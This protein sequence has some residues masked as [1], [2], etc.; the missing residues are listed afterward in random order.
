MTLR[1]GADAQLLV[2]GVAWVEQRDT[3]G[4]LPGVA[5]LDPGYEAKQIQKRRSNR[6]AFSLQPLHH[7]AT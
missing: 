1:A 4:V 3:Q 5:T 6:A 2:S 7:A